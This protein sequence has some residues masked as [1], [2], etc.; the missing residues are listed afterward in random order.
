[1]LVTKASSSLPQEFPGCTFTVGNVNWSCAGNA[2]LVIL[3]QIHSFSSSSTANVNK[4]EE[5]ALLSTSASAA[6]NLATKKKEIVL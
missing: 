3:L 6:G 4:L 5:G 1:M 2:S